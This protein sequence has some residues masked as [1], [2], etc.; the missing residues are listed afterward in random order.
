V[1]IFREVT[2]LPEFEKDLKKLAKRFKTI[3]EDLDNLIKSQIK[4]YH[5]IGTDNRGIFPMS[6]LGI[7]CPLKIYKIKKFTSRSIK[8]K[9]VHTGLRLIYAYYE[10]KDR[11][12]LIEIYFKG[13][14]D[15]ED[16]ERIKQY[17]KEVMEKLKKK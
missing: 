4:L 10:D 1:K 5:K 6:N 3:Q 12:E 17:C 15:N 14:K 2:R 11:V 9:G 8:G 16:K 7:Q 13:D